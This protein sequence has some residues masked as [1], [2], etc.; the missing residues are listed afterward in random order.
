M[1]TIAV[2]SGKG[3]VG[4]TN[5]SVNLGLAFAQQGMRVL[6]LDAD[7]GLA[8][9][10]VV[11]G[12]RPEATLED[13]LRGEQE[14]EDVL[15]EAAPGVHV[16][17][18]SSGILSLERLSPAELRGIATRLSALS[19]DFDVLL[20]D[21]GAGLTENVLFFSSVADHVLVVT[22]PEPAAITDSYALIKV[23]TSR[24]KDPDIH[25]LINQVARPEDGERTFERLQEVVRHFLGIPIR[26]AGM[27]SRDAALTD[28]VQAR[29][30]VLQACPD[31]KVTGDL[32]DLASRLRSL[33]ASSP[34]RPRR[35][36]W[37][38]WADKP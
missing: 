12:L 31:A 10:D 26:D 25:V 32:R 17:P 35:D 27:L 37:D 4:K 30:P 6:V 21:T 24:C 14:I 29:L 11:F 18:A 5:V 7:M 2:T 16:I 28:A 38:A 23:L 36:F 8:N 19:G 15:V 3:G 9:V 13:V 20:V 1:K 22:T 33:L 34:S